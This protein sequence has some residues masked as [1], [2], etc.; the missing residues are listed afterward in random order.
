MKTLNQLRDDAWQ[1]AQNSGFH[2]PDPGIP[3]RLALIHSEISEA[4]EE[5]RNGVSPGAIILEQPSG[6]PVG[7]AVELAD[8]LIRIL[9]LCGCE[10]IDIER[11]VDVKMQYNRTREYKHGR[12]Y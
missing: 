10:E 9:D 11:A 6:K 2:S 5:H 4:L 1:I 3:A 8:A 12:N 7:F